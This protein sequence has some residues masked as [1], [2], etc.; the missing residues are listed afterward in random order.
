MF[1]TTSWTPTVRERKT[2]PVPSPCPFNTRLA[3]SGPPSRNAATARAPRHP[4][5]HLPRPRGNRSRR[6]AIHPITARTHPMLAKIAIQHGFK[7]LIPV[8]S[9][10]LSAGFAGRPKVAHSVDGPDGPLVSRDY[11]LASFG[12]R[13]SSRNASGLGSASVSYVHLVLPPEGRVRLPSTSRGHAP[14]VSHGVIGSQCGRCMSPRSF[15]PC[16]YSFAQR[17]LTYNRPPFRNLPVSIARPSAHR[18]PQR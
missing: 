5:A 12:L 6:N 14:I 4:H 10:R 15:C 18:D 3:D 1:C 11:P 16:Q 2:A 9:A 7:S 8:D 13:T 17:A